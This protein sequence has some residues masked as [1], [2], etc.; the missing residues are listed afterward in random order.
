MP[1]KGGVQIIRN[2]M[3]NTTKLL[4][5]ILLVLVSLMCFAVRWTVTAI[6]V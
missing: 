3:R 5:V 4:E 6:L 2:S 1:E